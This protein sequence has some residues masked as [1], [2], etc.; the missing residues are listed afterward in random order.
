MGCEPG[1][2]DDGTA[3]ELCNFAGQRIRFPCAEGQRCDTDVCEADPAL[4][5]PGGCNCQSTSTTTVGGFLLL[6]A[7][8]AL[9]RRRPPQLAHVR[10]DRGR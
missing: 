6:L 9:V 4:N 7:A 5:G 10:R 2:S 8:L 3:E 1:C